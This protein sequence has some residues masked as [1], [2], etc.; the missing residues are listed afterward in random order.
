MRMKNAPA[1]DIPPPGFATPARK[2]QGTNS[3]VPASFLP[4]FLFPGTSPRPGIVL[5][6][7]PW[8]LE[9]GTQA[10]NLVAPVL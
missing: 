7:M 1:V 5:V 9:S 8:E 3:E 10:L 2:E 4:S 6:G